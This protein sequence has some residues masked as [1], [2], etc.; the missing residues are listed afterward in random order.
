MGTITVSTTG[1]DCRANLTWLPF[2][3]TSAKPAAC[4]RR[5]TSRK[6]SGLSRANL[7]L[8]ESNLRRARG[9]W[10][11][12]V[13]FQSFLKIGQGFG[14]GFTLARD[15]QLKALGNVPIAF[16]PNACGKRTLHGSILSLNSAFGQ[17]HSRGVAQ[18]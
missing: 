1:P 14:F 6:G 18:R 12:E 13:E 15:I 8:D 5:L 11:F 9:L 3:L 10:R 4:R 2:W 7:D 16:P 17:L